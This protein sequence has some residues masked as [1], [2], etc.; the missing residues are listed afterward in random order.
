MS[1]PVEVLQQYNLWRR[2]GDESAPMLAPALIG[3][4]IDLAIDEIT[5]LREIEAAAVS[6]MEASDVRLIASLR[7]LFRVIRL[8][9]RP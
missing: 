4:A 2:G 7:H 6:V 8:H 9:R 1:D 3:E 5:R